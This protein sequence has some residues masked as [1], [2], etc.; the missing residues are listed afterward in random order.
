ML[1][2]VVS[3]LQSAYDVVGTVSDGGALVTEA[4]RLQPDVIVLDITMP[5]LTGIEAAH[6][7]REA[8]N[9]A[10]LVF[11]TVHQE[12]EF[13]RECF[14]EGGLGYVTKSR[15]VTDLIPAIKEALVNHHFVSPSSLHR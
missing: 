2:R 3:L 11:L 8:G 1:E 13:V 12:S 4:Q 7:L 15:L 14:G 10:K 5:V 6:K 9:R